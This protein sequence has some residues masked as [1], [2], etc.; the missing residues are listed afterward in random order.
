MSSS[1]GSAYRDA[2]VRTIVTAPGDR[3]AA[4][5]WAFLPDVARAAVD[6]VEMR[7]RFDTFHEVLFPGFTHF[8]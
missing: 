1:E 4:H 8:L 2:G 3:N 7:D 5:A 6:L